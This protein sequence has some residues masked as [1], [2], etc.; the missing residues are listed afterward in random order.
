MDLRHPYSDSEARLRLLYRLPTAPA[1]RR[2]LL[3]SGGAD[4]A[5]IGAGWGLGEVS[6]TDVPG[7]LR[8][9]DGRGGCFDAVAL[10]STL[11][12][13]APRHG[14]ANRVVLHSASHLLAPGGVV[15]GHLEQ[16]RALRRAVQP[17]GA[18]QL[19]LAVADADAISGPASCLRSLRRAG[20]TA[21]E[22][23]YVQPH[24][25]SPMGL[26]PSEPAAARA[27]FLRAV[28]SAR[29]HHGRLAGHAARLLLCWLGLGGTLQGQL[30]YWAR[31]PC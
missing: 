1:P 12:P 9:A 20:L 29:H 18:L 24:V 31:K 5:D 17:A 27:H 13:R 4:D 14:V 7:L 19:L 11:V 6:R 22:C 8:L 23:Y 3:V 10:P 15:V 16:A 28:R 25:R 30:F 2:L 21:P 26:V